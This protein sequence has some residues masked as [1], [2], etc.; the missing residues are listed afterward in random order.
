MHTRYAKA[1]ATFTLLS[2]SCGLSHA[3]TVTFSGLIGPFGLAGDGQ[4]YSESGL[5]F[6][7]NLLQHWAPGDAENADP[8]GATLYHSEVNPP[9]VVAKTVAGS[10]NLIS[11]DLAEADNNID[12]LSP[13]PSI[14][15]SYTNGVGTFTSTLVLDATAGLQ[16]FVVNQANVSSFSLANSDFQVDNIVYEVAVVPE[17]AS[18]ALMLAGCA[19]VGWR[20]RRVP[21]R[22]AG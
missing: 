5:T 6:T 19:A 15:F 16:T 12:P 11:F 13:I 18:V 9:L 8:G 3:T 7:S 20:L 17:P 4:V 14:T 21:A 22:A 10:F 2:A 1:L